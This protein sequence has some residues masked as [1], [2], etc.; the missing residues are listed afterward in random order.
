MRYSFK[1]WLVFSFYLT[2]Y[3]EFIRLFLFPVFHDNEDI[4]V[5]LIEELWRAE[6][7]LQMA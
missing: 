7:F 3:V 2:F 6:I 1:G 4:N 5:G